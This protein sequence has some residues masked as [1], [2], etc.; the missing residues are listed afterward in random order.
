M[1]RIYLDGVDVTLPVGVLTGTDP[2]LAR[3]TSL[4]VVNDAAPVIFTVGSTRGATNFFKGAIDDFAIWKGEALTAAQIASL[5]DG[6]RTP[7]SVPEPGA[8]ALLIS[9]LAGLLFVRRKR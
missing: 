2:S 3:I 1:A 5:A 9:A 7:L 8:I 6:S 4:S